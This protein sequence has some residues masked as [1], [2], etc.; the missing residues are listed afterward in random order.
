[1]LSS[2]GDPFNPDD[3]VRLLSAT[4]GGKYFEDSMG[5]CAFTTQTDVRKLAEVLGAATGWDYT[6]EEGLK[7]GERMANLMRAFNIR[8]GITAE[9]DLEGPS[10]RYG[11]APVDGPVQGVSIRAHWEQMVHDLYEQ[12]GWDRETGKPLPAT[13]RDL[14]LE[15][16]IPHLWEAGAAR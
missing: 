14:G 10:E 16:V 13:L 7:A 3:V 4:R 8:H 2:P 6:L 5:T 1:M 15:E 9:L 11:S 12:N